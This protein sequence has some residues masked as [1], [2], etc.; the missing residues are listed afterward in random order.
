MGLKNN[1]LNVST[2]VLVFISIYFAVENMF[3][4][5]LSFMGAAVL[6]QLFRKYCFKAIDGVARR[7]S[8]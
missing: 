7:G 8:A 1:I 3:Y 5:A 2:L 4:Y 6:V